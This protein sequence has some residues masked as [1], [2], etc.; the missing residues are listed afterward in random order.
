[1]NTS[2]L[3]KGDNVRKSRL[4][5]EK[6][7]FVGF[8]NLIVNG[9][10]AFFSGF[11]RVLFNKRPEKPWISYNAIRVLENHLGPNSRVL[12]FGSGMSTI[13]YARHAGKV[14]SIENDSGWYEMLTKIMNGKNLRNVTY[15][16]ADNKE[17]YISFGSSESEGFDLIMVDGSFRSDCIERS[18]QLLKPGG[19]IYL[20]N[21]DKDSGDAGGDMRIAEN[22]LREFV[23]E[24]D[25]ELFEFTDFAPTQLFVQQGILVKAKR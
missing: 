21:A 6:G 15:Q 13:W 12:E 17:S 25:A 10:P 23:K 9:V 1:M 19:I 4:H 14:F 22:R 7:N 16:F 2:K 18:L 3:L 20:D 11:S 8:K 24:K 5:D